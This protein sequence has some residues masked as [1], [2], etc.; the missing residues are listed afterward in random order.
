MR[1]LLAIITVI[2]LT[3]SSY[4]AFCSCTTTC[5]PDGTL[6]QTTCVGSGCD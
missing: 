6:C 5:S 2:G 1:T 4:A 3:Y